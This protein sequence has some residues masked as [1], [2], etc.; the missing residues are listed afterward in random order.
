[1][2]TPAFYINGVRHD[3]G[4]DAASLLAALQRAA[5]VTV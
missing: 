3:G 1:M 4:W 2:S 5:Q